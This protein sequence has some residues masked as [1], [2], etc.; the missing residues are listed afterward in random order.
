[1]GFQLH[2]GVAS[3]QELQELWEVCARLDRDLAPPPS[4]ATRGRA[5]LR[6][7]RGKA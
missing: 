7:V 4:T 6:V 3:R 2:G 1:M 5:S